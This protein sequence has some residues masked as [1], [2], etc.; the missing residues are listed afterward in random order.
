MT[1]VMVAGPP[2]I[3]RY[4]DP[5]EPEAP[6][7]SRCPERSSV[8][9]FDGRGSRLVRLAQPVPTIGYARVVELSAQ[10]EGDLIQ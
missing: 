3:G 10:V 7:G 9:H 1:S 6:S 4:H 2:S 8:I 5:A